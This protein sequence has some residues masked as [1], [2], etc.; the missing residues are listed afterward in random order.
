MTAVTQSASIV[1][2]AKALWKAQG[3]LRPAIKDATNPFFKSKYADLE[4][5]WDACR[6]PL[7]ANGLTVTQFPGYAMGDPPFATLTTVL[8][9]DS[10]EW[11]AG[12]AGAPLKQ[13]D[14]Q[15]VGSAL[16]YLRRYAL[17][18]V[19]GVVA[20][21]DDGNAASRNPKQERGGKSTAPSKGGVAAP[22]SAAPAPTAPLRVTPDEVF[23]TR[24]T[25]YPGAGAVHGK[26]VRE[27][28]MNQLRAV[29]AG[30]VPVSEEWV[31]I[32]RLEMKARAAKAA[33]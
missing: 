26:T 4:A 24:D 31:A 22:T 9:H 8:I 20:E 23:P 12:T 16:T 2:L 1:A 7:Q 21:D 32:V 25:P 33:V 11:I 30:T 19:V 13:P 17:A 18:A 10:G 15:S 6:A 5:V 27:W 28:A 3:A 29:D 14:A